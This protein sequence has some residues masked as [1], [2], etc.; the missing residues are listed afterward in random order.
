GCEIE[1]PAAI[2][3]RGLDGAA[4]PRHGLA[5]ECNC[6]IVSA[7]YFVDILGLEM[8]VRVVSLAGI[9]DHSHLGIAG[10]VAE[11][12]DQDVPVKS[13]GATGSAAAHTALRASVGRERLRGPTGGGPDQCH[14]HRRLH[15]RAR[16]RQ[17]QSVKCYCGLCHNDKLIT[18]AKSC[19]AL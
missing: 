10:A 4:I 14:Q 13:H 11:L 6:C 1:P 19:K 2:T 15:C 18:P 12:I 3:G 16:L 9:A 8:I 17:W 5:R 7:P